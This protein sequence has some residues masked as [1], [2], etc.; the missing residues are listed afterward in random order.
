MEHE[1]IDDAREERNNVDG[2]NTGNNND[3]KR[4][5]DKESDSEKEFEEERRVESVVAGIS[6]DQ[7]NENYQDTPPVSDCEEEETGN[8]YDRWRKGSGELHIRQVFDGIKEFREAVLEY[9]L[10]GG[11]NI[12]FTRW[13][14]VKSE[15]KCGVEVDEGEIPCSWR[16]YC[17]YEE[18]VDLW[19][20][21]TFQDVHS[22]FKDGRCKILSDTIIA[23]M[24]LNEVRN[25]PL[26][27]PKVIQE[28]IQ[29]RYEL[30]TSIDQCG[31]AKNK[32]LELIQDE[33]DEQYRR[34]KDYEAEILATNEGAT[35]ELRTVIGAG[36]LEVFDRFYVC[37][38]VLKD[39]WKAHC[40]PV[41]GIDGCFL[42]S[43]TKG[44]LL[45]AVGRDANN[46]IYPLAWAVVHVENTESWVW[47]IQKLKMDLNLGNGDGFTLIS[48]RQKG[49]LIA[50]DQELHKVEHRM[51]ARHI[52][53]NLKKSFP[54]SP[55]MKKLFW[56]IV[57]S[58]NEPDYKA[59]LKALKEYDNEVY[60]ALMVRRPETCSR[61]FFRTSCTCEDALNNNSE[62]YNST[63]EKARSMPLVE[64]LETMRR[65]AMVRIDLRKVKST[66]HKGKFSEK[67]GKVI[68][69]ETK[70]RKDCRIYPGSTGEFEVT[71]GNNSY[72]VNMKKKTC[73]CRRWDLTGIPCRHALR[74]VHDRKNY[75]TENLV[76]D[77]YLTETW[78]KQYSDSLKPVRGIKF[79]KATG[80]SSLEAPPREKKS[81]GRKKKPQK[82][83]KGIN[84]SPTKGKSVTRHSR[85]MHCS[86]CSM[87]GHYATSCA[88]QG[89]PLKPRPIKKKKVQNSQEGSQGV[90]P[91][92]I[93]GESS[94]GVKL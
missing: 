69:L 81:K 33:Y 25:D 3:P 12:Q 21:K 57:E 66:N 92:S 32:A 54:K 10:Q 90:E 84:E 83:I 18:S 58:F 55:Q 73:S 91:M 87:A 74:V 2:A 29:L 20:V 64:M 49:L 93:D 86:H 63:L 44:Q 43:T 30:I 23:K 1:S 52:Y 26:M 34:I 15:A 28:Q 56:R 76:S 36:D 35:T 45:A 77:W 53:G 24:F 37:F 14:G 94:Q 40:R 59:N 27:K 46:Q 7:D 47:F 75:K 61:A 16:I 17:S 89:V 6:E 9:A 71:E 31:K 8:P 80:E 39:T 68:A 13:G 62:S 88:N 22:C 70:Y 42:K 5:G 85:V 65:Q 38:R 4:R 67:V 19:M 79:W 11:W 82:R 41:F 48:D 60:E 78:R 72:S 51:C 50:V